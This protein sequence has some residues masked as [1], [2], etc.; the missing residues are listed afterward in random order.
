VGDV[1]LP[2][3]SY[4]LR[5]LD[6]RESFESRPSKLGV[7]AEGATGLG[8]S[9][10]ICEAYTWLCK[11]YQPGDRIFLFGFSRGA[12][13]VRS[14]SGMI[15]HVGLMKSEYVSDVPLHY[16]RYRDW[17]KEIGAKAESDKEKRAQNI[18]KDSERIHERDKLRIHFLGVWDTVAALGIPLWGWSFEI[19]RIRTAFHDPTLVPIIDNAYHSVAMDELRSSF[20]PVLLKAPPENIAKPKFEQLWFRGAHADVGS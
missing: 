3:E 11:V 2:D 13:T 1:R 19:F 4:W 20:M 14:L 6:N 10:N 5:V 7:C 8:I 18:I 15:Y 16:K 12:F 9:Q 17:S